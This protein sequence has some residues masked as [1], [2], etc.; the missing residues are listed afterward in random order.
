LT[1]KRLAL[2]FDR[3]LSR[4]GTALLILLLVVLILALTL[5]AFPRTLLGVLVL[6]VVGGPIYC[7]RPAYWSQRVI[8]IWEPAEDRRNG[9][10]A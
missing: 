6:I 1:S 2:L 10:T 4:L 7:H 9:A 3:V 8:G 5:G